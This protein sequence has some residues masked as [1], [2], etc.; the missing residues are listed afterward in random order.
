MVSVLLTFILT[1][2]TWARTR[3]ALQLEVL[4]L[5]Y[6]LQV[7][8]RT[9]Q[10]RPRIVQADRWLWV[11]LSHIWTGWGTTLVIAKPETVIAWYRRGFRFWCHEAETIRLRPDASRQPPMLGRRPLLIDLSY[12]DDAQRRRCGVSRSVHQNDRERA[13]QT[14]TASLTVAPIS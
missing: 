11:M 3:A 10:P 12:P 14:L 7:L 1:L 5:R 8:Q 4:A 6:Q 2:R 13:G 9:R